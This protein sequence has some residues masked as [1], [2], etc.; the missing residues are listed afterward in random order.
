MSA[1][2]SSR[3]SSSTTG[4][5]RT[6]NLPLFHKL[7]ATT[8][9]GIYEV[10]V[11]R[12]DGNTTAQHGVKFTGQRIEDKDQIALWQASDQ[13]ASRS[14]SYA[15]AE[16]RFANED[17]LDRASM[18]DLKRLAGKCKNN[19]ELNSLVGAVTENLRKAYWEGKK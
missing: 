18:D 7:N 1:A 4:W 19:S 8:I 15:R 14:W 9:G 16:K 3:E 13:A 2:L 10:S 6:E 11:R 17:L 12:N 5:T